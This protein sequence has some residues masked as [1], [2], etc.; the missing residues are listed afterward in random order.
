M[1]APSASSAARPMKAAGTPSER[2]LLR[3]TS[4]RN[5]HFPGPAGTENQQVLPARHGVVCRLE[6]G[7]DDPLVVAWVILHWFNSSIEKLFQVDLCV[8]SRRARS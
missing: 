5:A 4:V 2:S 1:V 6:F 3:R 8:E 7:R